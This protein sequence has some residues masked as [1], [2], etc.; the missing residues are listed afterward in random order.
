MQV[1]ESEKL[2]FDSHSE[3]LLVGVAVSE[4]LAGIM[5]A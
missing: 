5:L 1:S 3:V 2:T 4:T